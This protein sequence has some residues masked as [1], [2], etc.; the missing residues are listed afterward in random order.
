MNTRHALS[1]TI[2]NI[3]LIAKVF[4]YSTV[5]ILIG[6]AVI[7]S[8]TDPILEALDADIDLADE[9]RED[10]DNF[11]AG[12][13][14]AGEAL[15]AGLKTFFSQNS[16]EIARAVAMYV[17]I[18]VLLRL[19]VSFALVPAA[20]VLYNK[21]SSNFNSGFVN[22]M[23]AMAGKGALFALTYTVITVPIDIAVFIVCY[24]LAAWLFNALN[25]IGFLIAV[26]VAIAV[27]AL[28]ISV[29][30]RWI[31]LTICENMKFADSCKAFF[32]DFRFSAVKEV[33]P[34]FLAM[35]VT[36]FGIVA[37][38]AVYTVGVVPIVIMP[39]A[40]VGYNCIN[41]VAYF[42]ETKRKYYIDERIVSPF[43]RT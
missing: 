12:N 29:F 20:Y 18:F 43:I 34:S 38:T 32:G 42:N 22:A 39:A 17:V 31:P 1:L 16:A 4:L 9:I 7:V 27:Y 15:G 8:V 40:F 3:G 33:Y 2:S 35:L 6:V 24:F 11:Y 23:I 21:M 37:A 26:L 13:R 19:G 36:V 14:E 25:I 10:F 28:R 5:L 30:G 41:L